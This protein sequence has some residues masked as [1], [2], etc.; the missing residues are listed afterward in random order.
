MLIFGP[1][2]QRVRSVDPVDWVHRLEKVDPVNLEDA[3]RTSR[4]ATKVRSDRGAGSFEYLGIVVVAVVLI[5]AVIVAIG[6]FDLGEKIACQIQQIGTSEVNCGSGGNDD[7]AI[8]ASEGSGDQKPRNGAPTDSNGNTADRENQTVTGSEPYYRNATNQDSQVDTASVDRAVDAVQQEPSWGIWFINKTNHEAIRDAIIGLNGAELDALFAELSDS[9]IRKWVREMEAGWGRGMSASEQAEIWA[10]IEKNASRET[11]ERIS[12]LTGR[13]EVPIGTWENQPEIVRDAD[14]AEI[15]QRLFVRGVEYHHVAQGMLGDC[16]ALAS[17][18][19][20][21][22][23]DPQLIEDAITQNENGT[24][25]VRLYDNGEPVYYTVTP[26]FVVDDD[27]NPLFVQPVSVRDPDADEYYNEVW[28]L[29]ME[30]AMAEHFGGEYAD[31]HGGWPYDAMEALTGT[32]SKIYN[33]A[34]SIQELED[35]HNSGAVISPAT[36]FDDEDTNERYGDPYQGELIQAHAYVVTS[37][38]AEADEITLENPWG[39]HL[40]TI[41][42]SYSEFQDSFIRYDVNEGQ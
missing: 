1:T 12:E 14:S 22:Q 16:W 9:Q 39:T 35:L 11:L 29:V 31:I 13:L 3:Q 8:W 30:K 25:T 5:S 36:Y 20:F 21:A 7:D 2:R 18:M 33:N 28:P 41:K 38:N 10:L 34:P 17:L 6:R 32:E 4:A 42:M 23:A 26:D 27:G 24:Y 19:G 40:P 15:E 37:V